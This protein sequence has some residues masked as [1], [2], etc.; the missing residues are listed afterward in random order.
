MRGPQLLRKVFRRSR[1]WDTEVPF[2]HSPDQRK[3]LGYGEVVG[4]L[5]E[6]DAAAG[7]KVKTYDSR[8][9]WLTSLLANGVE[10]KKSLHFF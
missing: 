8:Q 10:I 5:D 2:R 1:S 7:H 3:G 4:S 6:G 9:S